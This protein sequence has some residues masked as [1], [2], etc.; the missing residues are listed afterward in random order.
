MRHGYQL[1]DDDEPLPPSPPLPPRPLFLLET[2]RCSPVK[3]NNIG[4][5]KKK[6]KNKDRKKIELT[7]FA[8]VKKFW[9]CLGK[10]R[11]P[12]AC[13]KKKKPIIIKGISP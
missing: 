2:S 3:R 13:V 4:S 6:K 12:H 1:F 9:C 8:V 11:H 10:K 5:E 7:I